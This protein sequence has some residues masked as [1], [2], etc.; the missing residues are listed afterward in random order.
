MLAKHD[1]SSADG[2]VL[3]A[4]SEGELQEHLKKLSA[5]LGRPVHDSPDS[6]IVYGQGFTIEKRYGKFDDYFF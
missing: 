6:H 1:I 4:H 5:D 3:I 2:P